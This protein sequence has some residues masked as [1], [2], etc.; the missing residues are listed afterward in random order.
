M[1]HYL[2]FNGNPLG[3]AGLAALLPAL[4][5]LPKLKGLYLDETNTTDEGVASLVAQPTAGALKSLA[6]PWT[7]TT[8]RSPTPAAPRSPPPCSAGSCSRSR[9]SRCMSSSCRATLLR[10]CKVNRRLPFAQDAVQA[11]LKGRAEK[12]KRSAV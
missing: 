7:S 9:S 11:A 12:K 5:Q 4:R 3:D 2:G 1:L 10:A 8:T 6:R